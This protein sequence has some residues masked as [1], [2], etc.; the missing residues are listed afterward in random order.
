MN[1][2]IFSRPWLRTKFFQLLSRILEGRGTTDRPEIPA[3]PRKILILLPVLLGDYLVGTPLIAGVAK[4]FPRA[5]IS[6]LVTK[7]SL[8]LAEVDPNVDRVIL[9][10]KLPRWPL[11]IIEIFRYQPDIVI[12][13]KG[14]PATTESIVL[15]VS[16][17]K[18]KI[19]LSHPSHDSLLNIPVQHDWE[20]EHRTEAF[21][22]L[23]APFGVDPITS[24]RRLHVGRKPVVES[25]ADNLVSS[26]PK[27]SPFF[28]LNL[29][30]SRSTRR[31]TLDGWRNLITDLL[32]FKPDSKFLVLSAPNERDMCQTLAEEFDAVQTVPTSNLLEAV[33]LIAR[34]DILVTVDTGTVQAAAARGI[35]LVVL[36]NGDHEVYTRFGPQSIQH[37]AILAPKGKT[38]S[39][40]NPNEVAHMVVH[41]IV[42][43]EQS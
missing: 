35:P 24:S 30:A 8:G 31:W 7:T 16:R 29:S 5:E 37:K 22:R 41:L 23:L 4:R 11:S 42:E 26:M 17:A 28:S 9:Y 27:G 13:P 40:I 33:A 39:D 12:L 21:A 1:D 43:L 10:E 14:H 6:V 32:Q 15:T 2:R 3:S 36:Y 34:T 38:V 25:W 20:N 19:G 18:I